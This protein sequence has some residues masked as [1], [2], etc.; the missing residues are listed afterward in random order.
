MST[1]TALNLLLVIGTISQIIHCSPQQTYTIT[2]CSENTSQG[3]SCPHDDG[4]LSLDDVLDKLG[5]DLSV[6][7]EL[8]SGTCNL[9]QPIIFTEKTDIIIKGKGFQHTVISCS[10]MNAGLVFN[11]SSNIELQ[12]LT[13]SSCGANISE[14]DELPGNASQA[15]MI[16]N[17]TKVLL[18]QLVIANSH[19]YGL[20]IA[21]SYGSVLLNTINFFDNRITDIQQQYYI[22]GGGGL[23]ILFTPHLTQDTARYTISSCIFEGNSAIV[24]G[25]SILSHPQLEG[26]GGG[27]WLTI[28][29]KASGIQVSV[30]DC[31]F[32]N[33]SGLFG[34]GMYVR[35]S[36]KSNDCQITVSE[37][38]FIA[39]HADVYGGGGT[40]IGY[41]SDFY[42][43]R[44]PTN[45]TILFKSVLFMDNVGNIGGGAS[46]FSA[47]VEGIESKNYVVFD[48]CNFT[49]NSA[50]SGGSAID[51]RPDIAVQ[52]G[53]IS[54]AGITFKN[55]HF[56]EN[57][58]EKGNETTDNAI[59]FTTELTVKFMGNTMFANNQATGLY[60]AS[61]LLIFEQNSTVKFCNNTGE[62]G[63]AILLAG[64]SRMQL[65][66]HTH[67]EFVNNSASHGGAICA[68]F[69]QVHGFMFSDNCFLYADNP[70]HNFDNITLLFDGN[71]ASSTAGHNIFASSLTSCLGLC[72]YK[73]KRILTTRDIFTENCIAN[74]TFAQEIDNGSI[75]TWPSKIDC[76]PCIYQFVP[77]FPSQVNIT[78]IDE[79][80]N[81][82]SNMYI[83]T[84]KIENYTAEVSKV[85]LVTVVQNSILLKGKPDTSGVIVI[86]NS[87][88]ITLKQ[89]IYFNLSHCPPGFTIQDDACECSNLNDS[90]RYFGI[91]A[92]QN[93]TALITLGHWVGYIGN[94]SENSLFTATC[95]ASFCNYQNKTTE[96][97]QH[98]LPNTATSQRELERAVCGESREGVLCAKCAE[99]YTMLYHSRGFECRRKEH[100]YCSYGVLLYIA[101]ELIPVTIIFLIILLFNISLTTGALYSLVF[102][103]QVLDSQFIDSFGTVKIKDATARQI[104]NIF[105]IVYG[106]FNL[107]MFNINGLSFCLISDANAM[108]L[109]M[110]QYGTA[111]YAV[112]LVIATVIVLQLYS[113]YSCV[114]LGKLCGRKNIR[115]S[116]VDGLSA[117]LV[118]CYFLCATTTFKILIPISLRGIG[119]KKEKTIPFFISNATYFGSGHLPYAIPAIFCLL[120]VLIPLPCILVLEPVLT[121]LFSLQIWGLKI[122][123]FY[124]KIRMNC[125]P[126]LDSFQG[127]FKDKQR[128][129]AG[130]YFAYRA[131][132]TA[133]FFSPTVFTCY[134]ALEIII[135]IITFTHGVM[136]PHK[137]P[138]HNTLEFGILFNL[139]FVN[140]ITLLNYAANVWGDVDSSSEASPLVWLQIVA[141]FLPIIYFVSYATVGACHKMKC[142]SRGKESTR[143]TTS[144]PTT[145]TN[146]NFQDSMGFPARL[147]ETANYQTL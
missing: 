84:A 137:E 126:F 140:T 118:L 51:I 45:N 91:T 105:R 65:S 82:V 111:V 33:N 73:V 146:N 76:F 101:S 7:L 92:C 147:L 83:L 115:G 25:A 64:K 133:T 122:A 117:F 31:Q 104:I 36:G 34:G 98:K 18:Q 134:V 1:Q 88:P 128:F 37:S 100:A 19:G 48:S 70:H 10:H 139:L 81:D 57:Y 120:V 75:A 68:L 30:K 39:N 69:T 113:C 9:T 71:R 54:I 28:R 24:P 14:A 114:K 90:H 8:S 130:L 85:P 2:C 102:Y 29:K 27:L 95:D 23:A 11:N 49:R 50:K 132:V 26:M 58:P 66:N 17:A 44:V 55:T 94:E 41:T 136:R 141:M 80:G 20:L 56:M 42:Q 72:Q 78:Q 46:V 110:F 12:E 106:S 13:I 108:D 109:L 5:E 124:T 74:F 77:G 131:A 47:S 112:L 89:Y 61:S 121:K 63:G 43:S 93:N 87:A 86:E 127:S 3:C 21:N 97:G 103:A 116:I 60:S 52:H 79:M 123:Q 53:P 22:Q 6:G 4:C 32:R 142:C 135:F 125:M 67:Y 62:K 138:W 96:R 40:D 143:K 119:E 144:A 15:V 38:A 99:G 59:F 107:N 145:T 16:T 129:F 35:I